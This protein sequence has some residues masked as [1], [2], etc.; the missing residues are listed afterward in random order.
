ME[1]RGGRFEA[2]F[3]V[4]EALRRAG[5]ESSQMVSPGL[6]KIGRSKRLRLGLSA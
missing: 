4:L 1:T 6:Y 3:W 2:R 5:G